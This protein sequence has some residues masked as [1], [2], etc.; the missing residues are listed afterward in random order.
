MA[1]FGGRQRPPLPSILV[2][3]WW[4]SGPSLMPDEPGSVLEVLGGVSTVSGPA[5]NGWLVLTTMSMFLTI[6]FAMST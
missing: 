6:F 5:R 4:V 1:A 3:S 2:P